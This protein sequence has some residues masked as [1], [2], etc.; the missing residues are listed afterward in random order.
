MAKKGMTK[1]LRKAQCVRKQQGK[2]KSLTAARRICK[3]KGARKR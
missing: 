2:G 1:G 3:V